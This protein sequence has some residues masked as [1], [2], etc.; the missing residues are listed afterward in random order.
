MARR[1]ARA[2]LSPCSRDLRCPRRSAYGWGTVTGADRSSFA[3]CALHPVRGRETPLRPRLYPAGAVLR[4]HGLHETRLPRMSAK[5]SGE[6]RLEFF[7][8]GNTH[9]SICL[10]AFTED[11]VIAGRDV[12]LE[13]APPPS[14]T[15]R[16]GAPAGERVR[17]L[18]PAKGVG[19]SPRFGS[20][21]P[22]TARAPVCRCLV[23]SLA[24]SWEDLTYDRPSRIVPSTWNVDSSKRPGRARGY[25]VSDETI[26]L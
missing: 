6:R 7:R 17:S 22:D 12:T 21:G 19:H 15:R 18:C 8:L 4:L 20:A 23:C 9:C 10:A 1:G 11:G 3:R 14:V 25:A 26:S 13:H 5:T 24:W 2:L 16:D